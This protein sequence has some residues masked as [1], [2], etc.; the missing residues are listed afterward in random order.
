MVANPGI[1]AAP[2]SGTRPLSRCPEPPLSRSSFGCAPLSE[3][4]HSSFGGRRKGLDPLLQ[5]QIVRVWWTQRCSL[6]QLA[7]IFGVSHMTVY[8]LVHRHPSSQSH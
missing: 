7:A 8:R 3:P 6:R 2:V 4:R 1:R 5:Q